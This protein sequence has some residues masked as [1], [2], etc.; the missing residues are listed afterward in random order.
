MDTL[1]AHNFLKIYTENI[2]GSEVPPGK[3]KSEVWQMRKLLASANQALLLQY[4]VWWKGKK[5]LKVLTL[6]MDTLMAL[7]KDI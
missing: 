1:K 4:Q 6:G 5:H 3:K 7:S 2:I